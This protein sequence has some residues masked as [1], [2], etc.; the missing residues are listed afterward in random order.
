MAIFLDSGFYLGLV[1]PQD[2][3][4]DR[5]L[6]ILDE[7]NEGTYGQLFTSNYI[8]AEAST[9]SAIRSRKDARVIT[10]MRNYFVGELQ[11]ASILY[12]TPDI[13]TTTWDLFEKA[14]SEKKAEKPI[15]FIDCSNV[16]F[17]QQHQIQNIVAFDRHFERWLGC[18]C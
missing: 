13:N 2:A 8:L 4:R 11:L 6:A 12:S 14:N 7:L 18:V 16:I 17:C 1:H 3:N 15:S 10:L 5:S 9:L